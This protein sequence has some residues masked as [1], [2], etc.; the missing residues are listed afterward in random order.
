MSS[1]SSHFWKSPSPLKQSC[2]PSTSGDPSETRKCELRKNKNWSLSS[3]V[4]LFT[5]TQETPQFPK[6][7]ATLPRWHSIV[8]SFKNNRITLFPINKSLVTNEASGS[9]CACLWNK[10]WFTIR[11]PPSR[12]LSLSP[13]GSICTSESVKPVSIPAYS[14]L[15]W[16]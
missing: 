7:Q 9:C 6:E 1:L 13:T 14:V 4:R 5:F 2:F 10:T 11:I 8:L 15:F 16:S 12:F 3:V